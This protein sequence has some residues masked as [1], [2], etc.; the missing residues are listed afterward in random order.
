MNR[1]KKLE[2]ARKEGKQECYICKQL[3]KDV[4]PYKTCT[5]K[6]DIIDLCP[7]CTEEMKWTATCLY[8]S[9]KYYNRENKI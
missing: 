8:I 6:K 7:E 4:L 9:R 2:R 5:G 1:E 3:K